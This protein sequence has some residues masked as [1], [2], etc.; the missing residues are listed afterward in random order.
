MRRS[1]F[2]KGAGMALLLG[3]MEGCGSDT[4]SSN[5][6]ASFDPRVGGS[7]GNALGKLRVDE[8]TPA[9]KIEVLAANTEQVYATF[10]T[11]SNGSFQLPTA[12]MTDL[13]VRLRGRSKEGVT[14]ERLVDLS[15][16][17]EFLW[18]NIPSHLISLYRRRNAGASGEQARTVLRRTLNLSA[19]QP[20][21]G[22]NNTSTSGFS[23]ALFLAVARLRGGFEALCE[24]VV[25]AMETGQVLAF[26]PG[27]QLGLYGAAEILDYSVP[28]SILDYETSTFNSALR[29]AS[30]PPYASESHQLLDPIGKVVA[31]AG[32][33]LDTVSSLSSVATTLSRLNQYTANS[34]NFQFF[35]SNLGSD[36]KND[37]TSLFNTID[38]AYNG[39]ILTAQE[40]VSLPSNAPISGIFTAPLQQV[41]QNCQ[42]A[43]ALVGKLNDYLLG[44]NGKSSVLHQA[45]HNLTAE[46]LPSL[47]NIMAQLTPQERDRYPAYPVRRDDLTQKICDYFAVYE[48]YSFKLSIILAEIANSAYLTT[49]GSV[50]PVAQQLNAAAQSITEN[51]AA[52]GRARGL[53]VPDPIGWG[54]ILADTVNRKIWTLEVFLATY[55]QARSTVYYDDEAVHLASEDEFSTLYGNVQYVDTG[56]KENDG[57]TFNALVALGFDG[58]ADD[59]DQNFKKYWTDDPI[60]L[61]N[62]HYFDMTKNDVVNNSFQVREPLWTVTYAGDFSSSTFLSGDNV[63]RGLAQFPDTLN[64]AEENPPQASDS[65]VSRSYFLQG[66]RTTDDPKHRGPS[67]IGDFATTQVVSGDLFLRYQLSKA[68]GQARTSLQVC[69][70]RATTGQISASYNGLVAQNPLHDYSQPRVTSIMLTPQKYYYQP[71]PAEVQLIITGFL[72]NG[73]AIDLTNNLF[74]DLDFVTKAGPGTIVNNGSKLEI[75]QLTS[76]TQLTVRAKYT[77]D[78]NTNLTDTS[79]LGFNP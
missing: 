60:A 35:F 76:Y 71:A 14:V 15:E 31:L 46:L 59:S 10:Q 24:I 78:G 75:L 30:L 42:L 27:Q 50:A 28:G 6:L 34:S 21:N 45:Q 37:I 55:D 43:A 36:V 58:L 25:R 18:L 32:M 67:N 12:G 11:S 1:E 52:L 22:T 66:A 65:P 68:N 8:V 49:D 9:T 3:L 17:R 33:Q 77:P 61:A 79:V 4:S 62:Y 51:Y 56:A 54:K 7:A 69:S 26:T 19:R 74:I 64:L 72:E 20:L 16:P 73:E 53:Y 29:N 38:T 23:P 44:T 47:W 39:I 5:S 41:V 57:R 13:R 63:D 48:A 40:Y 70:R 2:L